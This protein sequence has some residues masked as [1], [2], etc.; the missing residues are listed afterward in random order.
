MLDRIDPASSKEVANCVRDDL[1]RVNYAELDLGQLLLPAIRKQLNDLG[2]PVRVNAKQVGYELRC[3][4]P[5]SFDLEYTRLLGYG[6]VEA[7]SSGKKTVMVVRD[8][9]RLSYIPL[10]EMQTEDGR[11]RSRK[12]DL[13]S[14]LYRVSR[15]YMI[16]D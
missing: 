9:D 16:R 15:S 3:H 12:V 5:T 10:T 11:I 13:N 6:A 14:D 4:A 1:G 2:L 8:Y 7:L